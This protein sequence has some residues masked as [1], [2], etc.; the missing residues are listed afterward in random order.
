MAARL[1]GDCTGFALRFA[2]EFAKM[3]PPPELP[4]QFIHNGQHGAIRYNCPPDVFLVEDCT[5]REVFTLKDGRYSATRLRDV[6]SY[7]N[8]LEVLGDSQGP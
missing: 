4:C 5:A 6:N 8:L 3:M 7:H 1:P 2:G